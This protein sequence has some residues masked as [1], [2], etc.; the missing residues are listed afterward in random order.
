[1]DQLFYALVILFMVILSGIICPFF[2]HIGS[3]I[4]QMVLGVA[5]SLLYA[6]AEFILDTHLFSIIFVAPLV[7]YCGTTIDKRIIW[8]T[9]RSI[10]LLSVPLVIV[11]SFIVGLLLNQLISAMSLAICF[12]V[13]TVLSPTDDVAVDTVERHY[14][15]PETMM[16][17]LKCESIFN[18]VISIVLFQ[19]ILA[20]I[21]SN[22]FDLS[23]VFV[24]F[25]HMSVGGVCFGAVF[26]LGKIVL[27]KWL[28]NQGIEEINVHTLLGVLY[29]FL[30]FLVAEHFH[31]SGVVAVFIA[32]LFQTLEYGRDNP[33]T[34]HVTITA[35]NIW[36]VLAY[37]LE[38]AAFVI[39][40]TQLP[41]ICKE[42]IEESLPVSTFTV[43]LTIL[44]VGAALFIVRFLWA[45]ITLPDEACGGDDECRMSRVRGCNIFTLSGDRGAV[46]LA[47]VCSIPLLLQDGTPFP[48]R[49]LI[50]A[51]AMGVIVYSNIATHFVL[52]FFV[53]KK[54]GS[55]T[56]QLSNELYISVLED[57]VEQINDNITPET[58]FEAE[59]VIHNYE[60]RIAQLRHKTETDMEEHIQQ[61]RFHKRV[62]QWQYE[63]T[64]E[65]LKE[66]K[67]DKKVADYYIG[68]L[69]RYLP[70]HAK[71]SYAA[72]T[73][74]IHKFRF[75]LHFTS[76]EDEERKRQL[77]MM[78]E[79]NDRYVLNKL[80]VTDF[81]KPQRGYRNEYYLM[82]K[83]KLNEPNEISQHTINEDVFTALVQ[84]GL[85]LEV[86]YVQSLYE[87][88][89]ITYAV[90]KQMKNNI[91]LL[92]MHR[93]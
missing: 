74:M 76:H 83:R 80:L 89:T 38:G 59:I 29:P 11:T 27:V 52:P 77:A 43:V 49:D 62:T 58:R 53:H 6:D 67:I 2:P 69:H 17:V 3:P 10:L 66:G 45:Y 85:Q 47:T 61:L 7:Y 75:I 18:E 81:P 92:E 82:L 72:I 32:G 22:S 87:S 25:L 65:L 33:D 34:I 60:E 84:Y 71:L 41:G 63:H 9:R 13:M 30:V 57:V 93:E 46:T 12:M 51:I 54:N 39:V 16:E 31:V 23:A 8:K 56:N 1:M 15:I 78:L 20:G 79:S 91:A 42:L 24:S 55:A 37:S 48:Y 14:H 28:R 86:N 70:K 36:R 68:T 26:S 19:S 90:A 35:H 40:G 64:M 21:V 5:V 88:G 50:L 73:D 44:V 4:V